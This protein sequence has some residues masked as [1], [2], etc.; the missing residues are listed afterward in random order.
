MKN[1]RVKC[2]YYLKQKVETV[3][4]AH[5]KTKKAKFLQMKKW[6]TVSALTN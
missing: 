1:G 4:K 2:R 6:L 5:V 3:A